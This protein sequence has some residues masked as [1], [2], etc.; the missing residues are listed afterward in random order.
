MEIIVIFAENKKGNEA[1]TYGKRRRNYG[2]HL[3]ER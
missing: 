2:Y 1:V 3:E